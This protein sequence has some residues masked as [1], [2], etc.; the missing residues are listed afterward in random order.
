MIFGDFSHWLSFAVGVL[1]GGIVASRDFRQKFFKGLREFLAQINRGARA[2]NKIATGR[3]PHGTI[4]KQH[5]ENTRPQSQHKND[6]HIHIHP[7][8]VAE[9]GLVKCSR[10]NGTGKIQTHPNSNNYTQCLDCEGTG[11]VYATTK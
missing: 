6:I 7:S 10:C 1:V 2:Q 9:N 8:D 11:K 3:N 4:D 5:Y